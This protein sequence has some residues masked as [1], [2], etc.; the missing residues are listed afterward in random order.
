MIC[1]STLLSLIW[2][3]TL[4]NSLSPASSN[5]CTL[6]HTPTIN[7]R[8]RDKLRFSYRLKFNRGDKVLLA[9]MV[10]ARCTT[11]TLSRCSN[12]SRLLLS[13]SSNNNST[14]FN[15]HALLTTRPAPS[16]SKATTTLALARKARSARPDPSRLPSRPVA[17]RLQPSV[18]SRAGALVPA[19]AD[20]G[21]AAIRQ[22]DAS[23][24]CPAT[25]SA[26]PHASLGSRDNGPTVTTSGG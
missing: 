14:S 15:L 17:K 9:V 22:A 2:P 11:P 4:D 6:I 24:T 20:P 25:Y 21:S 1:L 18:H 12:R 23:A 8:L 16:S 26:R 19:N 7:F 13:S 10:R 5:S 3:R